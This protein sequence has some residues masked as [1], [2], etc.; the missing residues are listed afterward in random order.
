MVELRIL[1]SAEL[2]TADGELAHSFLTGPKRLALLVYLV[3]GSRS[4]FVRRDALLPLFWPAKDQKSAR[5]ALSN[6]LYHIRQS[7][8]EELLQARGTEEVG[9]EPDAIWCDALAFLEAVEEGRPE[10]AAR[11][12]RGELLRGFHVPGGSAELG[13]WLDLE[14]GRFRRMYRSIRESLAERAEAEGAPEVAAEHWRAIVEVD[15]L[16]AQG[17]IR[18]TE[19]LA[20][21]GRR[22]DAL[23]QA[24]SHVRRVREELEAEPDPVL[25]TLISRLEAGRDPTAPGTDLDPRSIAVL[26]LEDLGPGR[27]AGPLAQGLH[28]DLLSRLSGISALRVISR[29]S[30]LRY[31]EGR[32]TIPAVARQLG[33]GTILEGAVQQAGQKV[34]L[35]VQLIDG[36]T[37]EHLWAETYDRALTTEGIF[38][39]QG[40][41]A[42][43]IA[44][45]VQAHLTK[46]ER[47]RAADWAPT[48]DLAAYRLHALGRKHL[49][50]RTEEGMRRGADRFRRA[51]ARDPDYA[52]AWVGLADALTLLHDYGYEAPDAV[53]PQAREAA[54]RALSMDPG[55]AEAHASLGLLH[56]T[57]KEGPEAIQMLRRAVKL[58]PSYAEAHNWMSWVSALLGDADQVLASA[59]EAVELDPLSA[60][61][62][63]N[64]ALGHLTTGDFE[65]AVREARRVVEMEPEY[66]TGPFYQS[67]ALYRLGRYDEAEALLQGLTAA[68]AGAGPQATLGVVYAAARQEG[69]AQRVLEGMDASLHPFAAGLLRAAMGDEEGAWEALDRVAKWGHWPSLALHHFYPEVWAR[70]AEGP[71]GAARLEAMTSRMRASWGLDGGE[72]EG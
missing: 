63:V 3:L 56:A 11:L 7:L 32:T 50:A 54:E 24:R 16:H 4:G 12:H 15:P 43:R 38:A 28:H 1:G 23:K 25:Q 6:M 33:V 53:L 22:S 14:R 35:N 29:T 48:G 60:E 72:A 44:Q 68:W 62:V 37:D 51:I 70:L 64:L 71:E 52:P 58:K 5:N 69:Q 66:S 20:G 27:E 34:R 2:R 10:E 61:A 17:A 8:G 46:Q 47:T 21:A 39:L 18:L 31:R 45:S 40:E 19:L 42:Q 55:L 65:Q 57:L 41:L 49:D 9:V 67:L 59:R 26:P 36:R 30:V 13:Q